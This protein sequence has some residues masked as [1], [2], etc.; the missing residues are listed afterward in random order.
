MTVFL[1]TKTQIPNS[2]QI[3]NPKAQ[4]IKID[5]FNKFKYWN[6]IIVWFL[7]FLLKMNNQKVGAVLVIVYFISSPLK[8]EG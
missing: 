5:T 3:L 8:G 1:N 4:I 7:K 6:L 2:K